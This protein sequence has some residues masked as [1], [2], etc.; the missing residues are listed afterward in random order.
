MAPVTVTTRT[1]LQYF[2]HKLVNVQHA[3][4]RGYGPDS[5]LHNE[6]NTAGH[7]RCDRCYKDVNCGCMQHLIEV[8]DCCLCCT[9]GVLPDRRI[10]SGG[11]PTYNAEPQQQTR[12][13]SGC[14]R[15]TRC[16]PAEKHS[17]DRSRY[18]PTAG[19]WQQAGIR[20]RKQQVSAS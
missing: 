13:A 15:S 9:F 18:S 12:A 10:V 20:E 3:S 7:L 14:S 4:K 1:K 11:T 6:T 2:L 17:A 8:T 5:R 19:C 16:S